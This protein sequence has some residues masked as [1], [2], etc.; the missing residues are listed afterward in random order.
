MSAEFDQI[1]MQ[2]AELE[3]KLLAN[4]PMMPSYLKRIH[5][6][7]LQ[8]PELVHIIRD[9]ERAV[10]IQSAMQMAGAIISVVAKKSE[11]KKMASHTEDDI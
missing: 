11:S 4:D 9:E 7:L 2:I 8:H 3:A 5:A 10:I 1:R 6:A